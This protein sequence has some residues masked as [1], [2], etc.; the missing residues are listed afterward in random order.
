M[1][2]TIIFKSLPSVWWKEYIGLKCNT[3]RLHDK[4]NDLRFELLEEWIIQP[5]HLIVEIQNTKSNETFCRDVK[6]VTKWVD[7]YIISW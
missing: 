2:K 6:D 4:P 5:F 1:A 3:I 7:N